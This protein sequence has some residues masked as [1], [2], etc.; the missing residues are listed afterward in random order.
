MQLMQS[1]G[2]IQTAW[3]PSYRLVLVTVLYLMVAKLVPQNLVFAI[4][5]RWRYLCCF[6]KTQASKLREKER[7][8]TPPKDKIEQSMNNQTVSFIEF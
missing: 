3:K 1:A 8:T 6:F 5:I 7:R 4:Q 2:K